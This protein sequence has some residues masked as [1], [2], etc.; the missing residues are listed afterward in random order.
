MESKVK[1]SLSRRSSFE[2]ATG[3][4][5]PSNDGSLDSTTTT[6]G[7]GDTP[8]TSGSTSSNEETGVRVHEKIPSLET[9]AFASTSEINKMLYSNRLKHNL[10]SSSALMNRLGSNSS[11]SSIS[12][13]FNDSHRPPP[14]SYSQS[15]YSRRDLFQS[16]TPP[17]SRRRGSA[18]GIFHEYS[19]R[20]E[21]RYNHPPVRNNRS[22]AVANVTKV[23]YVSSKETP[24]QSDSDYNSDDVTNNHASTMARISYGNKSGTS[25]RRTSTSSRPAIVEARYN[26]PA[27]LGIMNNSENTGSYF[28]HDTLKTAGS[29]YKEK[30]R[31]YTSTLGLNHTSYR[32]ETL[33][34]SSHYS[35]SSRSSNVE[36]RTALMN[37]FFNDGRGN[38]SSEGEGCESLV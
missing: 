22:H 30:A 36:R 23:H 35:T 18:P 29:M 5:R 37:R 1:V 15:R 9:P 16:S 27:A 34:R 8:F 31:V 33:P 4:R 2:A 14:P 25:S 32:P 21:Q 13:V 11:T 7:H 19:N 26:D 17:L 3:Q 38:W 24:S 28:L 10:T 12:S 6:H 20:L